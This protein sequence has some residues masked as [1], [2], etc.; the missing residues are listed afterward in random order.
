MT[1]G[2]WAA[3]VLSSSGKGATCTPKGDVAGPEGLT[4]LVAEGPAIRW[5]HDGEPRSAVLD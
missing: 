3:L 1:A 4:E 5:L 2:P